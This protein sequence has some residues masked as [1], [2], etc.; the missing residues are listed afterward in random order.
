ML[1]EYILGLLCGVI[2][3]SLTILAIRELI[4]RRIEKDRR[5]RH[6]LRTGVA[7]WLAASSGIVSYTLLSSN[8]RFGSDMLYNFIVQVCFLLPVGIF[9][10]ISLLM[11]WVWV[12]FLQNIRDRL[13]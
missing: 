2:S 13:R 3:L 7:L 8:S 12:D 9:T 11:S 5:I 10:S 1:L 4:N 6:A